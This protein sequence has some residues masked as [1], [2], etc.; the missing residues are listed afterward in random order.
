MDL[1]TLP[2]VE[3]VLQIPVTDPE[4]EILEDSLVFHEIQAVVDIH[5]LLLGESKGVLEEVEDGNG[6]GHVVVGVGSTER[7]VLGVTN[8]R[9]GEV[10]ERQEVCDDSVIILS[11][12]E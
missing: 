12:S 11:E 5:L 8:D 3:I 1:S 4:L 6:G 10:I 2:V 7:G 9:R